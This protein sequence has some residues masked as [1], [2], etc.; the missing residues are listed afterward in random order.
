MYI[1]HFSIRFYQLSYLLHSF[2]IHVVFH[3][4]HSY[5]LRSSS[6][7]QANQ[8][9]YRWSHDSSKDTTFDSHAL[10]K[11]LRDCCVSP[12][13]FNS[14]VPFLCIALPMI[15]V[16]LF[17]KSLV[18]DVKVGLR[19]KLFRKEVKSIPIFVNESRK[20]MS[21]IPLLLLIHISFIHDI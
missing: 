11:P 6:I 10:R 17:W 14:F 1:I 5:F 12:R 7:K 2:L 19:W 16:G 15:R 21:F 20:K 4:I 9:Y 3:A 18:D 8:A 13:P